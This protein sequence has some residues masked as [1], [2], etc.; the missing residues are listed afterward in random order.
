MYSTLERFL[1]YVTY[2]TQSTDEAAGVPSTPGQMVLAEVLAKEL[3]QLGVQDVV[4]TE[5]AY[6]TGSLPSNIADPAKRKKV[7]AIGFIAH[8]DTATEVTG[9]N[10][11]PRVVKG[12]DGGDVILNEAEGQVLSPRDF[13]F[14]K[15]CVGKDLV[16]TDGN[17]LLGA[18][19]KAGIAEI[20]G[21]LDY[22][23]AHPEV[24]HGTVKVAFT[25]D[26][27]VGHLAKLLDIEAFG[28][29]FAYTLDG[30]PL[31]ELC[32][33]NFNAANATVE[34]RG[35]AVHPGKSKGLMLNAIT[36]AQEFN[37]LFPPAET[38]STTENYE[39]YYHC[40]E[41]RGVVE[42]M[43]LKYLIR[44]H[45]AEK[46]E[47]RKDF[48]RKAIR[49]MNEKYGEERFSLS[50]SDQYRNMR[51]KLKERMDIVETA[52]DAMRE[53]GVE[54][55]IIPMRGGTDGAALSWRGLI[56][57]N[58]FAGGY[59]HHGRF[60]FIPVQSMEKAT[61]MVLKILELYVRR[62]E[63]A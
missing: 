57:P 42:H 23:V 20:M 1:N 9:K 29:D 28:A 41:M 13:P 61:E 17:T 47:A 40:M 6:V 18:D 56:T 26:E 30:G 38:P 46:F 55:R 43:T 44:D 39:G 3:E 32:Y 4:V 22:L 59:N 21:A 14:L 51:E 27:E 37:A 33:E 50:M 24:E 25:P 31:G 15:D 36:L 10:V 52:M 19:N 48:M 58:L 49:W 63:N 45:D 35:R 11:K 2:D 12:Y 53:I 8:L 5:N 7:P 16:V 54:P 34:I 62:S 60:E